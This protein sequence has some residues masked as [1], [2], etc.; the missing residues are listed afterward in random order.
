[1]IQLSDPTFWGTVA[2]LVLVVR[3]F[4]LSGRWRTAAF[5]VAL[6][7][8]FHPR[9]GWPILGCLLGVAAYAWVALATARGRA[10]VVLHTAGMAGLFVL[11]QYAGAL[12]P[13]VP[14]IA[15]IMPLVGLPYVFL[16]FVHLLIEVTSGRLQRPGPLDTLAYLLPFHQLLAGPIERYTAYREQMDAPLAPLD[17][18]TGLRALDRI[19]NGFV[20]KAILAELLRQGVGFEFA[21]SGASNWLEM[22]LF[23]LYL[24]FDFSGYMDIVIGVGMLVGWKPPENFDW[25]YLS[26]NIVEF[27]TRWHITLGEFVRDYVF[28]PLNLELQRGWLRGRV[29]TAGIVCYLVTML[30]VGLW[31][32]AN[33]QFAIYGL[34]Q[35]SGIAVCK[36]WEAGLKRALSKER[37]KAYRKSRAVQVVATV[38]T[39]QYVA[40]SYLF[41]FHPPSEAVGILLSL[42]GL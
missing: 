21:G 13:D 2:A 36:L 1:M 6:A 7:V 16:R 8:L 37:M 33:L 10:A 28:N 39:F 31:H 20:K 41:A 29:L 30:L 23:A 38:V 42:V 35:G 22:N 26:R 27:W 25:P 32:R 18:D 11:S 17:A 40:A 3:T 14:V 15:R 34:L 12:W 24:Y 19:T 9:A 5:L 4:G